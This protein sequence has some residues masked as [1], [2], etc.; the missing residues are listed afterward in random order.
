MYPSCADGWDVP[1]ACLGRSWAKFH[2]TSFLDA[3]DLVS[4]IHVAPTSTA[5]A[6]VVVALDDG[7]RLGHWLHVR[8]GG[9]RFCSV[10]RVSV[11][12]CVC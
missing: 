9:V 3:S 7:A 10:C 8:G 11:T 5:N 4:V 6:E 1:T 2:T 12:G